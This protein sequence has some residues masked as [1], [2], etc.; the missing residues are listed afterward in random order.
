MTNVTQTISTYNSGISQQADELKLPG[1]VTTAK[2]VFPDV[3]FGLTKRPGAKLVKSLSDDSTS[4]N[5]SDTNGQWFSYYRDEAEQYIGQINDNGVV[6]MWSCSTGNPVTVTYTDEADTKAYLAHLNPEDVQCL[7]INDFTFV[8]NRS[9]KK[10]A[11]NNHDRTTVEMSAESGDI[12]AAAVN[13]AYVELKKISY[14]SQYALNIYDSTTTT[15]DIWT[16]TS[17]KVFRAFDSA[18]ACD[19]SGN[20]PSGGSLPTGGYYC[21][22]ANAGNNQDAYCPNVGTQIFEASHADGI[23]A[24]S[25]SNQT[26]YTISVTVGDGSA[27]DKKNLYFRITTIGQSVPQGGSATNPDYRCRYTTTID[28]LHGGEGWR[29]GDHFNVWM[30]NARY[31][32]KVTKAAKSRCHAN[33]SL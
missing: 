25:D 23:S 8:C 31:N 21:T 12:A 5:N 29:V 20:W 11:S 13:E 10:D 30:N 32:V 19:S 28:L 22:A 2:N 27:A 7:T 16:A 18:K 9:E 1:Q 17:L 3:T 14:A 33:I 26:A 24:S 15:E 4:S 6:R